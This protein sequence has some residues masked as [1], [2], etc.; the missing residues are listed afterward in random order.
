MMRL[1]SFVHL[2][3]LAALALAAQ[4]VASPLAAQRSS[5]DYQQ[6]VDTTFTFGADGYATLN[7]VSGEIIVRTG[8]AGEARVIATIERGRIESSFSRSRISLETH[9][10]AGRLGSARYEITVPPG[11]RISAESVSGDIEV[12]GTGA[13]LTASSVSG[14]IVVTNVARRIEISTV[15]GD[16]T[17]SRAAGD[18]R[19]E[20]VNGDVSADELSGDLAF[21][22]VSGEIDLRRSRLDGIRMNSVSGDLFYDGPFS[23]TGTYRFESHSGNVEFVLAANIGAVLALETYSGRIS[24][25]FPLTLQPGQTTNRNHRM[26]FTLGQGG[27]RISAESFSGNITI[28]RHPARGNNPE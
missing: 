11:T 8:P 6:R 10:V 22:T 9:S 28:R 21:E 1:P 14:E 23:P 13:D 7:I 27:T 12:S 19:L 3:A 15:S 16:L 18:I 20:S 17:L 26:E 5:R 2:A 4:P 25:D 24:S